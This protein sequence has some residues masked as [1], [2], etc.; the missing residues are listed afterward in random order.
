M[1]AREQA[2]EAALRGIMADMIETHED[3]N[4][5]LS[6][7]HDGEAT[8]DRP[9]TTDRIHKFE[10]AGLG[11]AP[12]RFVGM[13]EHVGPI[14]L[15]DGTQVGAPGQPMGTCQFCGQGIR[16][17]C[18]ILA[19]DGRTFVVG[20]DCVEKTGDGGLK[21]IT[22]R[23]KA[24]RAKAARQSREAARIAAHR[25]LLDDPALLA[26]MGSHPHPAAWA[27]AKGQ[28]R[29]DWATWMW[30]HAGTAGRLDLLAWLG[31]LQAAGVIGA[32]MAV[33]VE[34]EGDGPVPA[35]VHDRRNPAAYDEI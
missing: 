17:C 16:Y 2:L 11:K 10:A 34:P 4:A 5:E 14:A 24:D 8:E 33:P 18:E 25:H 30:A 9:M 32:A 28:T 23:L 6:S 22:D 29:R 7:S 3:Q 13:T 27:A 19:A 12:F 31:R 26:V 20:T 35:L 21:I 15:K 1:T